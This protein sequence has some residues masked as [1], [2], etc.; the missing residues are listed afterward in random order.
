MHSRIVIGACAAILVCGAAIAADADPPAIVPPPPVM[1]YDWSGAYLGLN[2]GHGWAVGASDATVTGNGFLVSSSTTF[3][4]ISGPIVGGQI[5][6][7]YQSGFAVIGFEL[8][9][10]WSRQNRATNSFCLGAACAETVTIDAFATARLR[11]GV[12]I[13]NV[14][15]YGTA[16]GSWTRGSDELAVTLGPLMAG[17]MSFPG[18]KF[19]AAAG[20]GFEVA[21]D[22]LS[23]KLEYLYVYTPNLRGSKAI[24]AA[25]GGGQM[26]DTI[27]MGNSITRIGLNYRFGGGRVQARGAGPIQ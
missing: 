12:A 24:P 14:L 21:F 3:G 22:R 27:W 15:I 9:G 8:D 20:S 2:G 19:G 7:N 5:G 16:G 13:N 6:F 23:L 11:L 1:Y 26:T 4:T 10:Q 17:N 18:N 25:L